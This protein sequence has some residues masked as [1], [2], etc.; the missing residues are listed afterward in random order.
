MSTLPDLLSSD[1]H[2]EVLPERWTPRM[3]ARLR[4]KAP[5]TIRLPDG[6]DA[7]VVDGQPPRPVN[8]I[9]LRAGRS[10][11]TWQPFGVKVD[12]TAG[13]GPPEQRLREQEMDGLHAEVLFPN[14]VMGPRLWSTMTDGDALR[15]VFQAYN[16]WLGEEYCAVARDRLIGLGVIPWTG[17]DDA[18]TELARCAR[19]G[20]KGVMLGVFPSGKSYPTPEDDRFWAAA[21]DVKMPLTV[22]VGFDRLGP[23]ASEPTFEYRDADPAMV[24]KIPG[25][26][27]VEWMSIMGLGPALSLSQMILSGVFDR[28]PELRI[29][30]AE[31]RLGWVP[32]WM[33]E[34]DYWYERHRHWAERLL[35]LAPLKQRPSDYVR[36]HIYF[37]VQHVER[38][39]IELRHHI[40][41]HRIM[42]ATDFPHIECDWPNTRP[43]AERLFADVPA[44]EAFRIAAG[45]MLD[46][47]HLADTPMG[48]SVLAR[49]TTTE[50]AAR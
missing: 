30:F 14:M 39:A 4:D 25:R 35:K 42:F 49:R 18:M 12:D 11:E 37:S 40:G 10:N 32:F 9:D 1:G 21:L 34:A 15:A 33:E 3:P 27:I 45:N 23:R 48:R 36:Q 13:V 46:Y 22:H 44:D 43:F 20:L 47:F 16:D 24:K 26:T 5:R 50:T 38:V 6:G 29:F 17:I 2:L 7:L 8:F 31:T 28:F 41:A 19:L